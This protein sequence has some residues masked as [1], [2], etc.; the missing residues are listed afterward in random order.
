V[1]YPPE[2][3]Y[4]PE[5]LWVRDEDNGEVVVGITEF[6]QDQLGKVVYVDLP[7]SGDEISAGEE[8]GAIESAKSVSDLIAPVSGEILE[9]NE[10]LADDPTVINDDPYGDGWLARVKLDDD[11]L[12]EDILSAADYAAQISG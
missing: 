12:P 8:M 6:A 10:A 7:E 3:S 9:V 2:L 1:E 4:S 5:H 11:G